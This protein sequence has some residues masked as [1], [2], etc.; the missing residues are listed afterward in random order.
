V[1]RLRGTASDW[2][3]YF[4]YQEAALRVELLREDI[5]GDAPIALL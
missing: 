3:G 1:S 2:A 4:K 5:G